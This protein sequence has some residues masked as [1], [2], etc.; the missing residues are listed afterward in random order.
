MANEMKPARR[1]YCEP[2]LEEVRLVSE[3][4]V[5][6]LCKFGFGAGHQG[7]RGNCAPGPQR[8][9]KPLGT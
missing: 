6:R 5:L 7:P 1:P 9:C 2:Q 4:A 8:R 3:E